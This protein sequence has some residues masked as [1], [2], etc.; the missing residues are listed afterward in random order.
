VGIADH[1]LDVEAVYHVEV[2]AHPGAAI[3]ELEDAKQGQG[4][5]ISRI[6]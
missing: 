2:M 1:A 5:A 4:G 6:K 3:I